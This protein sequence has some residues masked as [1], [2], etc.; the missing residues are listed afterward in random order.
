[1]TML[2]KN[3]LFMVGVVIL[4]F[5]SGLTIK[6]FFIDYP[7]L[8]MAP[9]SGSISVDNV[10][11]T[12][13]PEDLGT[14]KAELGI[15]VDPQ[16]LE[17]KEQALIITAK[18]TLKPVN[19]VP[20]LLQTHGK[21]SDAGSQTRDKGLPAPVFRIPQ[22]TKDELK[23]FALRRFREGEI[24]FSLYI[25]GAQWE[26]KGKTPVSSTGEAQWSMASKASGTL[27]GFL[28]PDFLKSS[29]GHT[30]EHR[31]K[32]QAEEYI[33]IKI[34]SSKSIIM[35]KRIVSAFTAF[36]GGL[37]TLPGILSFVE[38]QLSKR[39]RNRK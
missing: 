38:D 11:V 8:E 13:G 25:A 26:P 14:I 2:L 15:Q 22:F 7:T 23:E 27:D 30:G 39:K 19:F 29:G 31:I 35:V 33:P 28:K 17:T 20:T 10:I 16:Y 12:P 18:V 37:L 6:S 34:K 9:Y 36:F 24:A 21:G 4:S 5:G 3:G 32:F 1:M